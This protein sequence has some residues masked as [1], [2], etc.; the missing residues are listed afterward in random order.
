MTAQHCID[1]AFA[2]HEATKHHYHRSARSPGFMD[3]ANQPNPFR[4]FEGAPL[5]LLPFP[6]A[7]DSPP[8]EGLYRPGSVPARPLDAESLSAFLLYA[9]GLSAW[10]SFQGS[11]W[12]LRCNPSSG[13]LH[14][15]EGYLVTG[16]VPGLAEVPGVY[17]YAPREHGLER[18]TELPGHVWDTI[19]ASFPA[20]TFFVGLSSVQWREIWKY[21]ERAY[22]YCNHDAGHALAAL[23]YSAAALDWRVVCLD[24][25]GD[26]DVARVLG[27]DRAHDFADAEAE[28]PDLLAAVVP[29]D[30]GKPLPATL[31]EPALRGFDSLAWAGKANRL[32]AGH[33]EWEII[34][35]VN[36]AC[37]KPRTPARA[38]PPLRQ[39]AACADETGP[40]ARA[41]FR[42]RRSAVA[43]DGLSTLSADDF[44]G[45]L[46][47]TLP[48]TGLVPWHS[49]PPDTFVHLVLFV[50]RVDG[51]APGVYLL[52]RAPRDFQ[53]LRAA[54][55]SR[56]FWKEVEGSGLPLYQLGQ[57][58]VQTLAARLSCQQAIAGG[59][60]FSASMLAR[61]EAPIL[62]AGAWRY[63]RL[64][65]EAGAIGQVL[66]LD[67]EARGMRGTGIGCYFDDPMHE[68]LGLEGRAFQSLYHFTVGG[69]VEDARLTT[70]PPYGAERVAMPARGP[71]CSDQPE[72]MTE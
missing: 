14:P 65:W 51:L 64:F 29:A 70:L 43:M 19:S 62:E 56:L 45:M 41:I 10:K 30:S 54:A 53:A 3:W 33:V 20:G 11:R 60:A 49:L 59:G 4:R 23:A 18:R 58:N 31:P 44:F 39:T 15:T 71:E 42:Q 27:L 25:L 34:E 22:R 32:S 52:V 38:V 9:L 13:N 48:D 55:A 16:P 50:H 46:R 35:E 63:P 36:A 2:Y 69:A 21:G 72:E 37:R 68:M 67:A 12:E 17:H 7:D 8:Y 5:T 47:R 26:A 61:F 6:G 28:H 1:T 57:G 40:S 24:A 66:Y